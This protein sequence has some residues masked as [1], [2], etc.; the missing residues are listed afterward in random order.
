MSAKKA[1]AKTKKAAPKAAPVMGKRVEVKHISRVEGHGNIVVEIDAKNKVKACRWEVPEAPRFFEAM[2][3]GKSY[4]QIH[5]IVSRICGICS[6]GH[7]LCSIQATEDAMGIMVSDQTVRLRKLALHGE[8]LQSHLLHVAY[9]AL[10]D[11]MGVGSVI[12]LA[13][14]HKKELL[15]L[16]GLH[17]MANEFSRAT[18]GRTTHPQRLVPGGFTK[19]PTEAE[20]RDMKKM[21]EDS[22]PGLEAASDLFASVVDKLPNFTRETEYVGL[23]SPAEYAMYWGEVGSTMDQARPAIYYKDITNEYMVP[24]ST[25][26]WTKNKGESL[27]VGAL[28]RFNLNHKRL[29][30]LAKG[31]ARKLGLKAPC[32]NPYYNNLAQLVECAHSVEDSIRLIDEMLNSGI[33]S[34]T[35]PKITP[36]AGKGVGA[37]EV[38]RGILFH[39]YEYDD[40]GRILN[41]DCVIPTNQNHANIQKDFE[42]LVPTLVDEDEATIELKTSMLVR[43]YD[44]CISCSTHFVDMTSAREERRLV[45]FVRVDD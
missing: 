4:T 36:R 32:H 2:I 18:T 23:V 24:Q 37:V 33:K 1:T 30:P 14:T 41:A 31:I 38:P 34:E 44:P 25:A 39:A 19:V 12:P 29:S 45:K 35:E 26:K 13:Q 43:A 17:R 11:L 22:I 9:L 16:I 20:L 3:L 15:T 40:R 10:P 28:A 8:N 27:M 5:Q 7:Q 6:I 42:A 21:L